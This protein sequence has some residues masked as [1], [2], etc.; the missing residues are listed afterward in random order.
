MTPANFGGKHPQINRTDA[1][2]KVAIETYMEQKLQGNKTDNGW[3][4]PAYTVMKQTLFDQ[5]GITVT[6]NNCRSMNKT[7]MNKLADMKVLIGLSGFGWDPINYTV[8]TDKEVWEALL[9]VEFRMKLKLHKGKKF[10]DYKVLLEFLGDEGA[11]GDNMRSAGH[12]IDE[13]DIATYVLTGTLPANPT[14]APATGT[15]SAVPTIGDHTFTQT[16]GSTPTAKRQRTRP[17]THTLDTGINV[18]T[19]ELSRITLELVVRREFNWTMGSKVEA[20]LRGIT[21]FDMTHLFTALEVISKEK[22]FCAWFLSVD[23]ETKRGYLHSWFGLDSCPLY[24]IGGASD[25]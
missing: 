8:T 15:S 24:D 23:D 4:T 19:T 17:T 18:M 20:A 11:N 5:L 1:M 9:E 12:L 6:T 22:P 7:W 10:E 25:E 21:G 16:R 2:N 14:T 3:R 13:E